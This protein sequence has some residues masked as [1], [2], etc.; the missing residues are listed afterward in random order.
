MGDAREGHQERGPSTT[1]TFAHSER[2]TK[3]KT[4]DKEESVR[5]RSRVG[6]KRRKP[7]SD[8]I[9]KKREKDNNLENRGGTRNDSGKATE[10]RTSKGNAKG[11]SKRKSKRKSKKKTPTTGVPSALL[12]RQQRGDYAYQEIELVA[13][14]SFARTREGQRLL[15]DVALTYRVV[16]GATHVIPGTLWWRR[17]RWD[18][19]VGRLDVGAARVGDAGKLQA[20]EAGVPVAGDGKITDHIL[21]EVEWLVAMIPPKVWL[22]MI[23]GSNGLDHLSRLVAHVRGEHERIFPANFKAGCRCKLVLVIEGLERELVK[24]GSKGRGRQRKQV[25]SRSSSVRAE[26]LVIGNGGGRGAGGSSTRPPPRRSLSSGGGARR[27]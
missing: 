19:P 18:P 13:E 3:K 25:R 27:F 11:K 8:E 5:V 22:D 17:R 14:E 1:S 10:K 9:E 16:E 4:N 20:G 26:R 21:E 23:K 2:V 24:T 12:K 15:Q 7:T 6:V